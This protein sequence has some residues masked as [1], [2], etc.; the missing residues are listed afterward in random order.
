[1]HEVEEVLGSGVVETG[2]EHSL[3]Q[4]EQGCGGEDGDRGAVA[5]A[6]LTRPRALSSGGGCP[7]GQYPIFNRDSGVGLV[8]AV[9]ASCAVPRLGE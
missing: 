3:S 9:A 8:D 4:Q 7:Q 6:C 1:M 2:K 5:R